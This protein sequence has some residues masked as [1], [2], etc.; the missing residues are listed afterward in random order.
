MDLKNFKRLLLSVEEAKE[1]MLSRKKSL[2]LEIIK[3]EHQY[4]EALQEV[5]E[6]LKLSPPMNTPGSDKLVFLVSKIKKYEEENWAILEP[7]SLSAA[8]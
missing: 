5:D 8:D 2:P 6:L 4:N 3:D 1:I 7:T